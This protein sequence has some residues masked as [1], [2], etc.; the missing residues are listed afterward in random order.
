MRLA[1]R[2]F[3]QGSNRILAK[4]CFVHAAAIGESS[5]HMRKEK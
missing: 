2:S 5:A 1:F 4:S 3:V